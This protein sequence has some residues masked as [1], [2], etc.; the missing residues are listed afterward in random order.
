M[1]S[2]RIGMWY[3]RGGNKQRDPVPGI[4]NR[5]RDHGLRNPGRHRLQGMRGQR[6]SSRIAPVRA[7]FRPTSGLSI[8]GTMI[9]GVSKTRTSGFSLT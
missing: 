2:S 8:F 9:P 6:T 4:R 5:A 3:A 7:S 1:R